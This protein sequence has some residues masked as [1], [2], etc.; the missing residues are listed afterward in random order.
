MGKEVKEKCAEKGWHFLLADATRD[1]YQWVLPNGAKVLRPY[2]KSAWADTRRRPEGGLVRVFAGGYLFSK[3]WAREVIKN[4]I[5]GQG[6]EWGLPDDVRELVFEGTN[7]RHSSYMAQL[8][9][10]A[11]REIVV[12]ATSQKATRW[13]QI[14]DDDHLRACEEM[15]LVLAA[16][17]G[18]I[19]SEFAPSQAEQETRLTGDAPEC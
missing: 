4:R 10:W 16:I 9:S 3:A 5:N 11:E 14:N 12:K 2:K 17:A 8:N 19:P 13:V 18:Y 1:S 7:K 15:Q 6:S